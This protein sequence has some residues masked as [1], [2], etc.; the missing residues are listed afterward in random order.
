MR[1]GLKES[2][3]ATGLA[4][5]LSLAWVA[6]S[7][8]SDSDSPSDATG[9]GDPPPGGP[10]PNGAN[11]GTAGSSGSTGSACALLGN[12]TATANV[13]D[14]GCAVLARDT[15]SCKASREAQG[16]SGFWL[17]FSCSV[18]LTKSGGNV[19]LS[20]QN[21]PDYKSFYFSSSDACYEAFSSTVRKANPN[22]IAAQTITMTVPLSPAKGA[23]ATTMPGGV[24]GLSLNGVAIYSNAAAPGDD[25]YKEQYTFDKC[26]GHPDNVG[27]YHYHSEPGAITNKGDD[28]VGVMRD[29][30]PVYGRFDH[31][32]GADAAGLDASGGKTGKTVDSPDT[33]V[34]HYHVNLQ[35][36]GTESVYFITGGSY[37][38]T[39]GDCTGCK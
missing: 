30:F 17:K 27:R 6:C 31:E 23:S 19:V 22:Q 26:D 16:L 7:S 37:A 1:F 14:Y 20:S 21:L 12:T 5:A 35:T 38:G 9:K 3:G 4:V 11:T 13:N 32:T 18:T 15:S 10:G 33:A 24:I 25:I 2:L 39:P 28:F 34:Y 29:G 8:G 36:S